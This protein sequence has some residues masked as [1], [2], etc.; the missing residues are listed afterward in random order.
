MGTC[1]HIAGNIEPKWAQECYHTILWEVSRGH[2]RNPSGLLRRMYCILIP[3]PPASKPEDQACSNPNLGAQTSPSLGSTL[4][5]LFCLLVLGDFLMLFPKP[6]Q[7]LVFKGSSQLS[8]PPGYSLWLFF[9]ASVTPRQICCI[10]F[11]K[12]EMAP[13]R[14][15]T[16]SLYLP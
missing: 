5:M 12:N 3:C 16:L 14:N 4:K 13:W 8:K 11:S 6:I 7:L 15:T 9:I 10:S 1:T 2:R